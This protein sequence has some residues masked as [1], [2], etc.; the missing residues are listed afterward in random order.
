[1][2]KK[3]LIIEDNKDLNEMYKMTFESKGYEVEVSLNGMNA[4][5]LVTTFKPDVILLDIMMPFVSGY[6]FIKTVRAKGNDVT[7][8][9]NSNLSQESD[10]QK[11]LEL[12]ANKY[13]KK[14]DYDPFQV[15]D[16]V[17]KIFE[18]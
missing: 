17:E 2:S 18:T 15:F 8:I 13:L 5:A 12:G 9:V 14:A 7:I 3:I 16:E 11:S 1:M 6:D 10:V 4:V